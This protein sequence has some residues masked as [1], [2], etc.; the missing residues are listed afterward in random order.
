MAR[1]HS[2]SA[3][4]EHFIIILMSTASIHVKQEISDSSQPM[5]MLSTRPKVFTDFLRLQSGEEGLCAFEIS[6]RLV[7]LVLSA[8][9]KARFKMEACLPFRVFP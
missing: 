5:I 3:V 7:H 2:T 4:L 8:M 1:L 6:S 9:S